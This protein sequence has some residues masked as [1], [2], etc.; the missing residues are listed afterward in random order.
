MA[1]QTVRSYIFGLSKLQQFNDGPPIKVTNSFLDTLLTGWEHLHK[2]KIPKKKV[3]SISNLEDIH[4]KI[5]SENWSIYEKTLYFSIVVVAF[6][7]SFRMSE[8]LAV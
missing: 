6:F 2:P 7:G 5:F 4:R 8:I 1:P 3:I